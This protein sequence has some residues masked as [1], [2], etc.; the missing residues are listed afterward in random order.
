MTREY[1]IELN[2]IYQIT[3]GGFKIYYP[4]K[5]TEIG[6]LGIKIVST[7]D[8]KVRNIQYKMI[9]SIYDFSTGKDI[10]N[11]SWHRAIKGSFRD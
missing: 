9:K 8:N 5:V 4:V 2:K 11:N 7:V 3:T 10:Y 1:N 6:L